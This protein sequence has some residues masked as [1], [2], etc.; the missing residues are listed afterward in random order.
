MPPRFA[1]VLLLLV[2]ASFVAAV[3][4]GMNSQG[5]SGAEA[6]LLL[7]AGLSAVVFARPLTEAQHYLAGK[8]LAPRTWGNTRPF[9]F[10]LWG[11]GVSV[12]AIMQWFGW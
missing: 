6:A 3:L 7:I 9:L 11:I 8:G 5:V 10:V 12:I 1:V 4:I 2:V